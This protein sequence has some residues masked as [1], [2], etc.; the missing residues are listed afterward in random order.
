MS[1]SSLGDNLFNSLESYNTKILDTIYDL[2]S[3]SND[4]YT[5]DN[6]TIWINKFNNLIRINYQKAGNIKNTN[7]VQTERE[8]SKEV[9]R[10]I[11]DQFKHKNLKIIMFYAAAYCIFRENFSYIKC[12]WNFNQ[13]PDFK[14]GVYQG[15]PELSYVREIFESFNLYDNNNNQPTSEK[16]YGVF[17]HL[18]PKD[19]FFDNWYSRS[20]DSGKYAGKQY[21]E[22]LAVSENQKIIKQIAESCETINQNSLENTISSLSQEITDIFIIAPFEAINN[23]RD[24]QQFKDEYSCFTDYKPLKLKSFQGYYL[25]Q[26]HEIPILFISS[27][28]TEKSILVLNK[29]RLGTLRQYLCNDDFQ[30]SEQFK[31]EIKAFS[32]DAELLKNCLDNPPDGLLE[33]GNRKQQ[34]EYLEEKVLIKITENFEF[35]KHPEFQ[36]YI[37]SVENL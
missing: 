31:I 30:E 27:E 28:I 22:Q 8:L 37:I 19:C 15:F 24:N 16:D 32:E 36:G 4:I 3:E 7:K 26:Y 13:P 11:T 20:S 12:L 1:I 6:L 14:N 9:I 18:F 23:W 10:N 34:Q 29:S 33:K 17:N 35:I 25:Y 5:Q 21:G 2:L